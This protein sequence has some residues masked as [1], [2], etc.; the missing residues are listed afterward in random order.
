MQRAVVRLDDIHDGG[1]PDAMMPGAFVL[2]GSRGEKGAQQPG[3]E[4]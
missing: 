3:R 2:K 1:L 4:S